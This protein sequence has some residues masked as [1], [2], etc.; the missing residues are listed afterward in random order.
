MTVGTVAS[1]FAGVGGIDL[2]L[3]A[4]G[5]KTVFLSESWVPARRVLGDRFASVESDD[6]VR[7][8][9]ELPQTNV[10]TAGF[11]CT[12]LSQAGSMGGIAGENSSLVRHVFRLLESADPEWVVLENVPNM[13]AL[14]GGAAI[15]EIT[16]SLE[17]L[18]YRWAYRTVDT[19]S[20]GLPQ[21]RRRVLV[22]AS[23]SRRPQDVLLADDVGARGDDDY[24]DRAYGFYWTEGRG[25]L[26]WVKDA[27]PTL[28]GGSTIGIPSAPAVYLPDQRAGRRIVMPSIGDGERLQGLPA[29][30]TEAAARP[31][32]RDHRWKL[33]GNAVPVPVAAWLG[34][35]LATPGCH[36][37]GNHAGKLDRGGRWPR[38]AW[39][40]TDG[41]WVSTV[42]EWPVREP[43]IHLR[44]LLDADAATP[45]SHRAATGFQS[46]LEASGRSVDEAFRRDLTVHI[47][48]RLVTEQA[49]A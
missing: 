2:G 48:E 29:G 25:G 35:S 45:L 10:V 7:Q 13:L 9:A 3:K 44:D 34:R 20:T 21:R 1:L 37:D 39:G 27:I 11:P 28:K 22:V 32:G 14:H 24:D 46:R 23:R 33:V 18:G 47:S 19:R 40:S 38:A 49:P 26:G 42:S 16:T 41:A 12:D 17:A 43:Y 5:W 30:W 4:A 6:D 31:S 36:D 15:R 8:L